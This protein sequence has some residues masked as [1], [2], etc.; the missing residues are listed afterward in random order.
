MVIYDAI[1]SDKR[2]IFAGSRN[3]SI[4][5]IQ[6]YLFTAASMV[7]P[8]LYGIHNKILPYVPLVNIASLQ[9]DG[10]FLAGVTNPMFVENRRLYDVSIQIDE[11]KLNAD[12]SYMREPYFEL[13]KQFVKTLLVRIKA[14]TINDEEIRLAFNS[15]TQL[16]LDLATNL[17]YTN[18]QQDS[19]GLTHNGSLLSQ[20]Y[21]NRTRRL[22]NTHLFKTH[23]ALQKLF[24]LDK[25]HSIS[26]ATIK[27][28]MRTLRIKGMPHGP[29]TDVEV[30]A[31]FKDID[32][33]VQNKTSAIK[34]LYLLP[35]CRQGVGLLA[36]GLF[37]DD[38]KVQEST[39][40]ILSKIQKSC[41]AGAFAV[42]RLS[43]FIKMRFIDAQ[44][45]MGQ[46]E[47]VSQ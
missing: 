41:K 33:F 10:G 3:L 17:T 12:S 34:L 7:S 36:H 22:K 24:E 39:V 46:T 42:N 27:G 20:Q 6:N 25:S 5:Q 30:R 40:S 45:E 43:E 44:A 31:I 26:V 4:T 9:E 21:L 14:N 13:D 29:L 35:L 2:I 11:G 23:L 18:S 8:P 1:L 32:T 28:H 38:D 37:F 47:K 16:M 19:A 15:Y